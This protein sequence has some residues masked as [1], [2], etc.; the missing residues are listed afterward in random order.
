M[1][2]WSI[3]LSVLLMSIASQPALGQVM[4]C[5]DT[6]PPIPDQ[7]MQRSVDALQKRPGIRFQSDDHPCRH[8]RETMTA[9]RKTFDRNYLSG[10]SGYEFVKVLNGEGYFTVERFMSRNR[11][12]LQKLETALKS[13]PARKLKIEANTSYDFFMV[14]GGIVLMISSAVGHD[15]NG[16]LF[17]HLR[18]LFVS[19]GADKSGR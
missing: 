12:D 9:L 6:M 16:E 15:E 10:I 2:V 13:L 5:T 1:K 18:P 8:A 11:H 17:R 4:R 3:G 7:S 14:P 19:S